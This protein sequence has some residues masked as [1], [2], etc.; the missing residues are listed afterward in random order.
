MQWSARV[1]IFDLK[2]PATMLQSSPRA[3]PEEEGAAAAAS[4]SIKAANRTAVAL[5]QRILVM[6]QRA[7]ANPT[8][9]VTSPTGSPVLAGFSSGRTPTIISNTSMAAHSK[10]VFQAGSKATAAGDA[11]LLK[12]LIACLLGAARLFL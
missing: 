2:L 4:P 6:P 1:L 5:G 7:P 10:M 11:V 8:M 12:A 9:A 3:S